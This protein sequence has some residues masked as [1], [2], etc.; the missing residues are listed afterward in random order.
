MRKHSDVVVQR[1]QSYGIGIP[2]PEALLT[3]PIQGETASFDVQCLPTDGQADGAIA[4]RLTAFWLGR[5]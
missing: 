2:R 4:L 1:C 3:R 5:R